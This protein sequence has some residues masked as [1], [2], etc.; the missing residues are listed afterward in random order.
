ME[1]AERTVAVARTRCPQIAFLSGGSHTPLRHASYSLLTIITIPTRV[2]QSSLIYN[3]SMFPRH[4]CPRYLMHGHC[5]RTRVLIHFCGNGEEGRK[6]ADVSRGTMS[7]TLLLAIPGLAC[8]HNR[9]FVTLM[10][11]HT[12]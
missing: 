1:H 8:Q 9:S 2:L 10:G 7:S 11:D 3:S 12:Y 4:D 6:G 5:V